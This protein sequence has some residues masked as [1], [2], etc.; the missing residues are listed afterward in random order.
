MDARTV[1]PALRYLALA[2]GAVALALAGYA[3]Y[4]LYPRFDLPAGTGLGLL[5]LAAA[6]GIASFFSPCSFPLL[7]SMLA[8]PLQADRTARQRR[9]LRHAVEFAAAL[10]VGATA[11]LLLAGLLIAL[12]GGAAFENVTFTSATGRVIRSVVGMLLITL[13]LV[14]LERL[15]VN[16]RRF[17]PATHGFLR[18]QARL[19]RRHPMLGFGLFGFGYLLAGFG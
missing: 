19:R 14:Q 3:G 15:R 16:L 2:S 18:G 5:V 10:S 1:R 11:F 4:V 13:G 9:P 6:A 7:V 8:R 12:G 17:E